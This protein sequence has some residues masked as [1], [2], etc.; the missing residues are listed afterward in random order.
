[1]NT[2]YTEFRLGRME[3]QNILDWLTLIDYGPE[4]SDYLNRREPG[5]G[6]WLLTSPEY[7]RW[8]EKIRQTLFCPGI[9]GAGKTI[10]TAITVYDLEARYCKDSNIGLAYI[11]CNFRR[12]GE[13]QA[14]DLLA[15]VLKQLSQSMSSLPDQL[16]ALWKHHKNDKTRPSFEEISQTLHSVIS[17]FSRVFILIDALDECQA[18]DGCRTRFLDEIFALQTKYGANVFAT[19]R[20]IPE[21]TER[22]ATSITLEI[23]A[24]EED[25]YRYLDGQM[26]RLPAFVNRSPKLQDEI[27]TC[28]MLSVEGMCVTSIISSDKALM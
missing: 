20:F 12:R 9:P 1:M 24:S 15:S 26:F 3:D 11:Y 2:A 14:N 8:T 16:K 5:T 28:I 10:L 17:V 22:F 21:I 7:Q 13:Q 18:S 27:K 6:N 19:S 23:S 25:V 4:Q